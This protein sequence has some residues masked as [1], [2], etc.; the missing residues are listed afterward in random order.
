M[1]EDALD[2]TAEAIATLRSQ[3][4]QLPSRLTPI[5]LGLTDETLMKESIGKEVNTILTELNVHFSAKAETLR[6]PSLAFN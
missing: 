4:L 6:S 1:I 2:L 3:L 5:V